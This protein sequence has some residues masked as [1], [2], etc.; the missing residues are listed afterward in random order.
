MGVILT[1]HVTDAGGGFFMLLVARQAVLIHGVENA[2]VDRLQAVA[3]IGQGAGLD[4]RH[5]VLDE[6]VF[7]FGHQRGLHNMLIREADVFR[8][9]LRFFTHIT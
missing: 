8:I 1:E 2:A 4:D 6:R 7:H 5:G 9:I 3:H